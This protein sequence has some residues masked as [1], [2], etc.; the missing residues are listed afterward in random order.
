M[1]RQLVF[2]VGAAPQFPLGQLGTNEARGL[3][4]LVHAE[5]LFVVVIRSNGR[6]E[7][8]R[9]EQQQGGT[10]QESA[11]ARHDATSML[12]RSRSVRQAASLPRADAQINPSHVLTMSPRP[13]APRQKMGGANSVDRPITPDPPNAA[14]TGNVRDAALK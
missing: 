8:P 13:S 14:G 11:R 2:A 9:N 1:E 5:R 6:P 3:L 10:N 4:A 12:H 7:R